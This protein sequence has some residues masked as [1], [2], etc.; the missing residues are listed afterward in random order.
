MK[1]RKMR[2]IWAVIDCKWDTIRSMH[3]TK[4]EAETYHSCDK[5]RVVKFIEADRG[6]K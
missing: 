1:K 2:V 6:R 4:R 5:C 3:M